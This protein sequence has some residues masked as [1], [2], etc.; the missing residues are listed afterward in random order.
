ME[1]RP[2]FKQLF[3]DYQNEGRGTL[4]RSAFLPVCSKCGKNIFDEISHL[5][6]ESSTNKKFIPSLSYW[7][8]W[9]TETDDFDRLLCYNHYVTGEARVYEKKKR[10]DLIANENAEQK[11]LKYERFNIPK[12]FWGVT[13]ATRKTIPQQQQMVKVANE[14]VAEGYKGTYLMASNQRGWG[15]SNLAC[16]LL[17]QYWIDN[18]GGSGGNY[19]KDNWACLNS[20]ILFLNETDLYF[21]IRSTYKAN[22]LYDEYDIYEQLTKRTKILVLDDVFFVGDRDFIKSVISRLIHKRCEENG[23]PLI[24][25]TNCIFSIMKNVDASLTSRLSRGKYV[26][27]DPKNQNWVDLRTKGM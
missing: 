4:I 16:A 17:M 24:M 25:T 8:V 13:L 5:D 23:L 6:Y 26:S 9:L 19:W 18:G 3:A 7:K 10:G 22:A 15:K 21:M 11:Y 27:V 12:R 20:D 1:G 2:S 14:Y